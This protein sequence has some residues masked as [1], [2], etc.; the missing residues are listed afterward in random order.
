MFFHNE[1]GLHPLHALRARPRPVRHV[2]GA[3]PSSRHI[4][5]PDPQQHWYVIAL[6]LALATT[7]RA[8]TYVTALGACHQGAATEG[9]C[10]TNETTS[11]PP[12][13]CTTFYQATSSNDDS[14]YDTPGIIYYNLI[15]SGGTQVPS[16]LRFTQDFTSD[17]AIPIFLPGNSS[18]TP[19]SVAKGYE[20]LYITRRLD[21]S[22]SPP[23]YLDQPEKV[24]SWYICLT[25]YAYEY[26]TLVWKVGGG[27]NPTNPSC[28]KV[29]VRRVFT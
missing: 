14:A 11:S 24:K 4:R 15:I 23:R 10:Q 2:L 28:K 18:Y 7:R 6:A 5:R 29:Q 27:S 16:A 9:L 19:I 3:L 17:V 22:A 8:N 13:P 20:E 12:T 1:D 21:D 25:R 26:H